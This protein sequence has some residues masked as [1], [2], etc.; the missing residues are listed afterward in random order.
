[1]GF[2]L[3][4][5]NYRCF[6]DTRPARI[7]VEDGFVAFVGVNNSGKSSLLRF[8]FEF[9]NLFD[10]V[11]QASSELLMALQGY[12]RGFHPPPGVSDLS[13]LFCDFN[14][15]NLQIQLRLRLDPAAEQLAVPAAD[16]LLIT[17]HRDTNTFVAE[18]GAGNDTIELNDTNCD[19]SGTTI[20]VGGVPRTE[21]SFLLAACRDLQSTLYIGPFRNA[22]NVGTEENYFDIHVGQA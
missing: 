11:S 22:I 14:D 12:A 16:R 13:S 3:E 20:R 5:K 6:S 8:F 10:A 18:I 21:L 2:E 19:I 7:L 4:L 1:M 17:V 15:R 9:R